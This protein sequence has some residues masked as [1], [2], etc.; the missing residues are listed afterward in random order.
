V[1]R[2]RGTNGRDGV[3]IYDMIVIAETVTDSCFCTLWVF[4]FV[5]DVI[6]EVN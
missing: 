6:S 2:N 4:R 5:G 3:E 1:Y